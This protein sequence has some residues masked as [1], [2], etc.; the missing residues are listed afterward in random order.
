MNIQEQMKDRLEKAGEDLRRP[1]MGDHPR[2]RQADI[3]G[4][5]D[6][7]HAD[8]MGLWY[9]GDINDSWALCKKCIGHNRAAAKRKAKG[10]GI[11]SQDAGRHGVLPKHITG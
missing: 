10:D 9:T 3:V 6:Q 8:N 1:V 11:K 7:C 4:E 5:C 2:D